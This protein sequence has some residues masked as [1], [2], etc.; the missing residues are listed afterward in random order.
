MFHIFIL[1]VLFLQDLDNKIPFVSKT[2][3]K[4]YCLNAL[5]LGQIWNFEGLFSLP[6][7]FL[8]EV[9]RKKKSCQHICQPGKIF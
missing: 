7:S 3:L 4:I 2:C 5:P 6:L 8:M 9:F 1:L